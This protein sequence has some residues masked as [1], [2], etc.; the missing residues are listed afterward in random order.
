VAKH[1]SALRGLAEALGI[2]DQGFKPF[3]RRA[4]RAGEPRAL[5]KDEWE[6]LLCMPDR[7]RRQGKRGLALLCTLLGS[8]GLRRAEGSALLVGDV[9]ER[10]RSIDPRLRQ[11]IKRSTSWWVTVRYGKARPHPRHPARRGRPRR[12]AARVRPAASTE[13]LLLSLPRTG[14]PPRS[15]STRDITRIVARYPR[16]PGCRKTGARRTSCAIPSAR[17][18]PTPAPITGNELV[19]GRPGPPRRRI[20][21]SSKQAPERPGSSRGR[22]LAG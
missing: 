20:A 5:D 9:D 15:L 11:A 18:S 12:D 19:R 22:A 13:H 17:T 2:S 6:R 16:P 4:S 3:A 21:P 14:Q 1:L 10:R 8:T 7:R